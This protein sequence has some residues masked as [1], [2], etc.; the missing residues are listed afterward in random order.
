MIGMN[1]I[2]VAYLSHLLASLACAM[3]VDIETY[4][5]V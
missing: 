5:V 3:S 2:N 1:D 4:L